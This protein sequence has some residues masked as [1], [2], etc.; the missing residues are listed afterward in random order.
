MTDKPE[1][2]NNNNIIEKQV[3]LED[4][5]TEYLSLRVGEEISRLK[6]KNIKKI[7][8]KNDDSNLSGTDYKYQITSTENK[9][10]TVNSW[11]LWNKIKQAIKDARKIE[12]T[13]NIKHTGF[14]EYTIIKLQ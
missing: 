5:Q 1:E 14:N 13:L 11:V 2:N 10:L 6:I 3:T 12:I 8:N 9:I 7:K 4:I